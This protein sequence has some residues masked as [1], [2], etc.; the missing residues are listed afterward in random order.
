MLNLDPGIVDQNKIRFARRKK[1]LKFC[2]FPVILLVLAGAFFLRT[3]FYNLVYG[4]AYSNRNFDTPVSLSS[5]QLIG[6]NIQPYLAYYNRG[7]AEL[8]LAQYDEAEEDFR[9]S[10]RENPP[11]ESYCM[12]CVNLA[13]SIEMQADRAVQRRLFDDAL[14]LY[15][16]AESILF[17]NNCASKTDDINGTDKKAQE[18]K[19]RIDSKRR[20]AVA[21]M[22]NSGESEGGEEGGEE[23]TNEEFN[24][25]MKDFKSNDGIYEVHKGLGKKGATGSG[26]VSTPW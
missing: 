7:T 12:V 5:M 19:E 24:N 25:I 22:N 13:Y 3:S 6:N 14:V 17:E 8:N 10:L 9:A 16:R 1:L 23:V 20:R 2:I 21:Q 4:L 15:N 18:S 11:K 26:N